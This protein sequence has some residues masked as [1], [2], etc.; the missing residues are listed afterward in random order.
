MTP[1]EHSSSAERPELDLD[2]EREE[3]K[4]EG[5]PVAGGLARL[6]A[7]AAPADGDAD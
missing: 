7:P 3:G 5:T 2:E 1:E 6:D 4:D